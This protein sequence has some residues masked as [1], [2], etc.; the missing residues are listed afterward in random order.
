[1]CIQA[2]EPH[3]EPLND[4]DIEMAL[5]K[6]K[7]GNATGHDPVPARLIKEGGKDLKKAVYELS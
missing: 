5:G 1:M 4:V 3:V 2:A 6:L 7:Y